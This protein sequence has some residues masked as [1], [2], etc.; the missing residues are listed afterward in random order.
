MKITDTVY[1]GADNLLEWQM[2]IDGVQENIANTTRATLTVNGTTIDSDVST[3]AFDWTTKTYHLLLNLG[4]EGLP[5]GL[6][7]N[8]SLKIYNVNNTNGI[9][10]DCDITI[11]VRSC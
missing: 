9:I 4:F 1:R 3:D 11:E 6:Y 2:L 10:W 7:R 8:C 5:I